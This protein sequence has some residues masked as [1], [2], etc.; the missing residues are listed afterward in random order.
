VIINRND[1]L[2]EVS[3]SVSLD[4]ELQQRIRNG[5]NNA[6]GEL[7]TRHKQPVYVYCTRFVGHDG[8]AEDVFQ[9]VFIGMLERIRNGS[10]IE[11][12]AAYLMR[13]ARNRCLNVLRDRKFPV[14]I[15]D[16]EDR[17]GHDSAVEFD[18]HDALQGAMR[19]IPDENREALVL[20]EYGGYSYE[21]IA[22]MTEVPLTTVRKRI[23]RARQ[24]LRELLNP[25]G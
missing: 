8:T 19:E 13:S 6:F 22:R 2:D 15:A 1:V 18:A 23:F 20:C 17:L 11:N 10:E 14:D 5:D 4:R 3:Q 25:Q 16:V 7:Y 24:K 12:V 21:E 9:D